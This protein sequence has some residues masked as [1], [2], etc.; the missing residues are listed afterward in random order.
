[1]VDFPNL[2]YSSQTETYLAFVEERRATARLRSADGGS[3]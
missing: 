1:M 2:L 3:D